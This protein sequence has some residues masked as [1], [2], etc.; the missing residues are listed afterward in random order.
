M[1]A[2]DVLPPG[3]LGCRL[4]TAMSAPKS[5]RPSTLFSKPRVLRRRLKHSMEERLGLHVLRSLPLGTDL[6]LDIQHSL[7]N[8]R[9]ETVFDVGANV[10]QTA[11]EVLSRFPAAQLYCFEPV[12][13]NFEKLTRNT[14]AVANVRRFR[15]ALGEQTGSAQMTLEGSSTQFRIDD[16][17]SG[18]AHERVDVDTLDA[19]CQREGVARIQLLKIDTEGHDLKVLLGAKQLLQAGKVDL[20]QV[21]VGMTPLNPLHVPLAKFQELLEPLQYFSFGIYEQRHE[22]PLNLPILRRSNVVFISRASAERF[23]A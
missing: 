6:Y 4:P 12:S 15:T 20:V 11:A 13:E 2:K 7:P 18:G 22:W 5:A 8:L 19:F 9:V 16:S 23:R 21:E 14:A 1:A 3:E 10:G 17:A